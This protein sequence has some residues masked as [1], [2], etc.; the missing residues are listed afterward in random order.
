MLTPTLLSCTRMED[1]NF[2]EVTRVVREGVNLTL[3][4]SKVEDGCYRPVEKNSTR[5]G[6]R[7]ENSVLIPR[8]KNLP[9]SGG[10]Y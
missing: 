6:S 4:G 5:P 9:A 7:S 2:R 1:A 3:V 8:V 10:L